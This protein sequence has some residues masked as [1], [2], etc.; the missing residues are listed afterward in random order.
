[1][2]ALGLPD[3]EYVY[4]GME[5]IACG[6]VPRYHDGTLI[7]TAVG[8]SELVKRFIG[9]TG[10]SLFDAIRTVTEIPAKVLGLYPEKGTIREGCDADLAIVDDAAEH[11]CH[12]RGR[13]DRL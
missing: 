6:G 5:Y 11:L 12:D 9:F 10:C 1:M 3:G 2:Q 7:G 8:L 4:N 13:A